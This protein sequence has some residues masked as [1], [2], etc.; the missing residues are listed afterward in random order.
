MN[1]TRPTAYFTRAYAKINLT[2]DVLSKRADG[3]HELMTV[4][5]TIDLYD[6][7]CLTETDDDQV[8]LT[9][10][11]PE[12]NTPDNL[13]V[14]SAEVVRQH[15]G[16]RSGIHVELDKRIPFAAGLGGGSSDAAA[17]LMALAR[18]QGLSLSQGELHEMATALGSDV[19]FFLHSGLALCE[20]RGEKV[21][22]LAPYWPPSMRWLLLLKPAI[23]LSTPTIFRQVTP[24]DY[25]DGSHS[26][27]VCA[28]L[29]ALHAPDLVHLHNALEP[30]VLEN[31]PEVAQ[32]RAAMQRAGAAIAHLSGSGPTL[33]APFELLADAHAAFETLRGIGYEVYLTRAIFPDRESLVIQS[34]PL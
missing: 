20:G 8:H 16:W 4:M 28:A 7:I 9:C 12:L 19:P 34:S 3:Y 15:T 14:R 13:A 10:T 21:T 25:S 1:T 22:P 18:W 24:A 31:Y 33:Y 27:A 5:Q 23:N 32:A 29:S 17:V 11:R 6:I 30:I 26:R 2:L